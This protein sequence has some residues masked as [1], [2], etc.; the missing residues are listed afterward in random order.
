MTLWLR[1][2][3]DYM[4]NQTHNISINATPIENDNPG[5]NVL[6]LYDV[7]KQVQ[8]ATRKTNLNI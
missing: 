4:T 2:L 1:V 6:E 3:K 5:R 8:F 7:L